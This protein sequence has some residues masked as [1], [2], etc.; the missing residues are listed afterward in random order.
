MLHLVF[1]NVIEDP[2]PG[3]DPLNQSLYIFL[4]QVLRLRADIVLHKVD[5]LCHRQD[6]SG[7]PDTLE[8][9]FFRSSQTM[10]GILADALN[11]LDLSQCPVIPIQ[12]ILCDRAKVLLRDSSASVGQIALECG[13]TTPDYFTSVFKSMTGMTPTEYRK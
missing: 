7:L 8:C 11:Q 1:Q 13:F 4:T 3:I 6:K 10:V 2:I 5:K 9:G 12:N